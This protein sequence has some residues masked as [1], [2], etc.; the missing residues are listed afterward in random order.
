MYSA[1]IIILRA[2]FYLYFP[3]CD[4]QQHAALPVSTASC[5][6]GQVNSDCNSRSFCSCK[7]TDNQNVI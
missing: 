1:R 5:I 6:G 7:T 3:S 2:F 4:G